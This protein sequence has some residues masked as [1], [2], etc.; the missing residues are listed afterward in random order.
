MTLTWAKVPA[1]LDPTWCDALIAAAGDT[2]HLVMAHRTHPMFLLGM[3][4]C[5]AIAREYLGPDV[6]GLSSEFFGVSRGLGT[7]TDNDYV[8][9][10]PGTF[11]SVWVALADVTDR[12]GPLVIDGAPV[13]CGK[14]DAVVMD[15]DTPHRSCAGEGRRPVALFTYVQ[16]GKPFRPGNQQKRTEVPV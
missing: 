6:S 8:Q 12:N 4:Q 3:K 7:H 10:L 16:R 5:A 11:L 13:F 2:D 14:G 15:G 9:A 1:V